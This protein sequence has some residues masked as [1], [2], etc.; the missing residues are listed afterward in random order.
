MVLFD[1][2]GTIEWEWQALFCSTAQMLRQEEVGIVHSSH[3]K[4]D[5][6]F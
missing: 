5:A 4:P 2:R 1:I 3:S 6:C